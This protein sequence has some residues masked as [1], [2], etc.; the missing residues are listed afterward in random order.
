MMLSSLF[1]QS[2]WVRSPAWDL[3]WMFS[4]L[5]L[6]ALLAVS[7]PWAPMWAVVT[8][9]LATKRFV[10]LYHSWSTV[11][12]VLFSELL[13]EERKRN[14]AR[15]FYWPLGLVSVSM[16]LGVSISQYQWFGEKG[17]LTSD[18]WIWAL[19]ISIFWVGHFWHFGNQDFGVLSFY[20]ARAGQSGAH[21]RKIDRAYSAFMMFAIQPVV[22]L[23]VLGPKANPFSEIVHTFIPFAG[24]AVALLA[25]PCVALA[26]AATA[27]MIIR[28]LRLENR[29][30][31]RVMYLLV[32]AFHPA[33]LFFSEAQFLYGIVYLWSH[34]LIATGLVSYM[35]MNRLEREK[36][37]PAPKAALR[38]FA[39][40]GVIVAA[41]WA[42]SREF[43]HYHLLDSD[44]LTV[45]TT[46]AAITAETH[47]I[48]GFFLGF[49]LA[50]QLVHYY[51]DR[52]LFRF[53]EPEIR[54]KV[55][56]LFARPAGETPAY[57]ERKAA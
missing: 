4:G 38:H 52:I 2:V 34:W 6:A 23:A 11:Q 3:F 43:S 21:D 31:P 12:A 39:S 50:E 22:F 41:V 40:L 36:R 13:R 27:F 28:E 35:S 26:A 19:Y 24:G 47:W 17:Q 56:P 5:W 45:R 49:F 48:A 25:G 18:L 54:A 33:F 16:L 8:Y 32:M 29:S 51:C 1:R 10:A 9:L 7:K 14:R 46:L 37:M 20:R 15:Y 44:G 55:A 30:G 42:L 57:G 53:R